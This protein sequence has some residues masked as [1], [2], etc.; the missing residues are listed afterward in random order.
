MAICNCISGFKVV[1][2]FNTRDSLKCYPEDQTVFLGEDIEVLSYQPFFIGF[3][4]DGNQKM[5][6]G[7]GRI[8]NNYRKLV[9]NF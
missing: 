3:Q 6:P 9:I 8:K 7:D 5:I 4:T 1:S 2:E